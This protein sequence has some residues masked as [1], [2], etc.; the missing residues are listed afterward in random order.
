M[1]KLLYMLSAALIMFSGCTK[2]A[3][4]EP[5]N[6]DKAT[7]PTITM[8]VVDDNTIAVT[9]AGAATNTGYYSFAV[10]SGDAETVDG[11]SL[12]SKP[13]GIGSLASGVVNYTAKADTSFQVSKL[14]ANSNYTVYAVA[15]TK[16]GVLSEVVSQSVKTTDTTIPELGDL[17]TDALADDNTIS[18]A[19]N[20]EVTLSNGAST[21]VA[22][23]FAEN[24]YDPTTGELVQVFEEAIPAE[25][26]TLADGA[27]SVKLPD[28]IPG[29]IVLFTM[30]EGVVQNAV[31]LRS[32]AIEDAAAAWD[33][34]GELSVEGVGFQY[35]K[36]AWDFALPMIEDAEGNLIRMPADTVLYFSD[37]ETQYS[38]FVA[39]SLTTPEING[40]IKDESI[41]D[42]TVQYTAGN[43]RRVLYHASNFGALNDTTAAVTLDEE[44]DFGC[45]VGITVAAESFQD[46]WGNPSNE[47]TTI[48]ETEDEEM[49]Y[50][51]YFYS[52]GYTLEDLCG[53]YTFQGSAY[54][55][56]PQA[57][58][59]VVIAPYT[60]PEDPDVNV[61]V[62][63]LFKHT[64]CLD[65]LS[66][67]YPFDYT[68]FE[69]T[70]NF[71]NGQLVLAGDAIGIAVHKSGWQ[72]YVVAWDDNGQITFQMPEAGLLNLALPV[73]IE[74]YEATTWDMISSGVLS[75]VSDD[76]TF[77]IPEDDTDD[78]RP[79]EIKASKP[80]NHAE[81][82]KW[83]D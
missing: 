1:K 32:A 33:S 69:G 67:Y 42:I 38:S 6:F 10:A 52:Y 40:I 4:D 9:V 75:K 17:S 63:D 60:D 54:Y 74:L 24:Y 62:Y 76:Y 21:I 36:E 5:I 7:A 79:K 8:S 78:A 27:V 58:E 50:G 35:D 16:M 51:N 3:E 13:S 37:W 18:F 2:F 20:E 43:D 14:N 73:Y 65:D 25:N 47:F 81:L 44:P 57:D 19:F 41:A 39:Q 30:G 80:A 29:A 77:E 11:A 72:G 61:V 48:F 34:D 22:H 23:Y 28:A 82:R 15:A 46:L 71:H 68:M 45:S 59:K 31:G 26:V 53:T 56:G 66:A 83:N 70:F 55:A 64:T 12:L 49:V